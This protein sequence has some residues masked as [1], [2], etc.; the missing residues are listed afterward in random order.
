VN[1][2][3]VIGIAI[4]LFVG[5]LYL[6]AQPSNNVTTETVGNTEI[7]SGQTTK[8]V[9]HNLGKIPNSVLLTGKTDT[10]DK[11]FWVSN[12]TATTFQINLDSAYGSG[13]IGFYWRVS[14]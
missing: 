7:T 13:A 12:E 2:R 4:I 14:H 10:Q 11:R 3:A 8:V 9:T 1:S 5:A 6:I